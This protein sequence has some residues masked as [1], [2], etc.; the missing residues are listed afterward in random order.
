MTDI[1]ERL[2]FDSARCEAQFSKGVATNILTGWHQGP[3]AKTP[4]DSLS[5]SFTVNNGIAATSNLNFVSPVMQMK[6]AGVIDLPRQ[7]LNLK[8]SPTLTLA[9]AQGTARALVRKISLQ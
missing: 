5:A 8:V 9:E 7:A 4:F 2:R 3:D 6:G 1:I